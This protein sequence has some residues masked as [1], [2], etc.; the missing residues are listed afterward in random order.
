[1]R[2]R[3]ARG[4]IG[5]WYITPRAPLDRASLSL[6]ERRLGTSQ[7]TTPVVQVTSPVIVRTLKQMHTGKPPQA[8]Q[9]HLKDVRANCL[10]ASLLRT[11]FMSQRRVTSCTSARAKE[12][13]YS[14]EGIVTVA[15]TSLRFSSLGW[16]VT[17]TFFLDR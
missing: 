14:H 6:I 4:V 10:C 13:F 5:R 15:L 11:Q 17:P 16:S 8:S 9:A 3:E 7:T 12:E 2:L 1:M